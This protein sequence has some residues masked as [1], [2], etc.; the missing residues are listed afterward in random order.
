MEQR[1]ASPIGQRVAALKT[2]TAADKKKSGGVKPKL[3]VPSVVS[4]ESSNNKA[5]TISTKF[6]RQ[7]RL[8]AARKAFPSN[9]RFPGQ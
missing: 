9:A 7:G 5:P 8:E 3:N 2:Q 6:D 4:P 1:L